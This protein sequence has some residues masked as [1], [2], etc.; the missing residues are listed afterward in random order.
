MRD[1][2]RTNNLPAQGMVYRLGGSAGG[3]G[4]VRKGRDRARKRRQKGRPAGGI[5]EQEHMSIFVCIAGYR[6]I[7]GCIVSR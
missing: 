2:L 4:D 6:C 3:V 5:Y 1:R 7:I